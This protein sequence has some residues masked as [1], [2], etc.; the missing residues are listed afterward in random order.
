MKLDHDCVRS[1]LLELEEKLSLNSIFNNSH[2]RELKTYEEFGEE[3]TFYTILKLI[4][5]DFIKGSSQY[6]FDE[7][8]EFVISSI[9]YS[10]HEFLDTIRDSKIWSQTKSSVS[11]LSGV[12]LSIIGS[13][14]ADL[15]KKSVGLP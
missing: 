9:S 7:S 13:V 2:I 12:S 5:A 4:E 6:Y 10:G 14:A 3:Q 15:V 8:Y 1:L 11:A